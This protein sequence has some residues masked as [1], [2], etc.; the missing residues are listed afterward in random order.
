MSE[1]ECRQRCRCLLLVQIFLEFLSVEH[2]VDPDSEVSRQP[3][4]IAT[5]ASMQYLHYPFVFKYVG[6][7]RGPNLLLIE[8]K[9]VDQVGPVS[10]F[11]LV[12]YCK[13]YETD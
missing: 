5:Q 2:L 3:P 1:P 13:L 12:V 10:V 11:L 9:C 7:Q 8:R 6:A 4:H